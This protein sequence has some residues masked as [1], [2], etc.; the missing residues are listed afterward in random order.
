VPEQ[1]LIPITITDEKFAELF[2]RLHVAVF[3]C[4]HWSWDPGRYYGLGGQVTCVQCAAVRRRPTL[5]LGVGE[6]TTLKPGML[7]AGTDAEFS[8]VNTS[9]GP[10][11]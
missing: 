4:G 7:P 3:S 2:A 10:H 1:Q 9:G 6:L 8:E 11:D 5:V